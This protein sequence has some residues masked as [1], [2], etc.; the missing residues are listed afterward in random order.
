MAQASRIFSKSIHAFWA[1]FLAEGIAMILLGILAI[2]LPPFI[3]LAVTIL[4]G[5]L[6]I[7]SGVFGILS[8]LITRHSSAF[9]WSLLSAIVT[10]AIGVIL[11]AWPMGGMISLSMAL[12]AFLAL[13]GIFAIGMAMDHRR[14]LTPK[15]AWLLING[16]VDLVFAAAIIF[17]LPQSAAW[18]LGLI[19]GADMLIGGVTLVAMAFDARDA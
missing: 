7:A 4:L 19:I 8:T 6:L 10:L 16:V 2:L 11:F 3:G 1:L 9:G 18:A 5:W 17:W 13:D 14:R 15:W 12:A